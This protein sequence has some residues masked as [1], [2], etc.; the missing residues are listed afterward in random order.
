M[1]KII[2]GVFGVIV[3]LVI[4]ATGY[5]LVTEGVQTG[6]ATIAGKVNAVTNSVMGFDLLPA[7]WGDE[8][9]PDDFEEATPVEG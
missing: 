7:E 2:L 1:K 3:A 9:Q 8:E 6:Y 5:I 4:G